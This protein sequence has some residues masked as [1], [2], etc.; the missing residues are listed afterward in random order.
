M[1]KLLGAFAAVYEGG[2][3][4]AW[5]FLLVTV[6][7]GGLAAWATGRAIAAT[8]RQPWQIG[9]YAVLLTLTVRFLQFALFEAPLA[10][11]INALID[12]AVVFSA[13]VIGFRTMRRRQMRECY[14]DI[15]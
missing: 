14:P 2:P 3:N 9:A 15:I 8:W 6:V 7:I 13:T 1:G 4:A 11:L 12:A 10:S 5:V